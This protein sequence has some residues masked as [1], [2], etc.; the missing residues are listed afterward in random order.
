MTPASVSVQCRS[1][2]SFQAALD[3]I[4]R[5]CQGGTTVLI[6]DL[7]LLEPAEALALLDFFLHDPDARGPLEPLATLVSAAVQRQSLGLWDLVP[8]QE[9]APG[10]RSTPEEFLR[11]LPYQCPECLPCG[12]FPLCMGYG[13][14]AR[15]CGTWQAIIAQ[16]AT[17]ARELRLLRR[18]RQTRISSADVPG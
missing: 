3:E 2:A 4:R 6:Q 7:N 9:L 8:P 15:S 5:H 12:C 17:A 1:Q 16:I 14:W 13:A 11:D 18:R 10:T